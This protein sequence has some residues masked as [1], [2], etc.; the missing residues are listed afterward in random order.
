MTG[1]FVVFC[2]GG[3]DLQ[4]GLLCGAGFMYVYRWGPVPE[5]LVD[6]AN[7]AMKPNLHHKV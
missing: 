3:L 6:C 2:D 7:K 1:H 5:K 4:E